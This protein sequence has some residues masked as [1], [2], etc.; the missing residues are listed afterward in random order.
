VAQ[1]DAH[2]FGELL[3]REAALYADAGDIGRD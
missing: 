2:I 1:V 3:L